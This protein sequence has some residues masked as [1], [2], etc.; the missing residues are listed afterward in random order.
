MRNFLLLLLGF[1]FACSQPEPELHEIE[2][3]DLPTIG[4]NGLPYLETGLDGVLRCSWVE[5]SGDTATLKFSTFQNE[6]WTTP[7]KVA[8]GTNWFVNWADYP[9]I[10]ASENVM[11]AHYLQKSAPDTY[12]Y[13]VKVKVRN[14]S[15]WSEPFKVHDDSTETEHGFVSIIPQAGDQFRL[16]WLDGRNTTGAHE[17]AMTLR[18]AMIDHSGNVS[19][20]TRLDERV[21]DCCATA[22]VATT[23]GPI[24]AYR[25]RSPDEIRDISLVQLMESSELGWVYNESISMDNWEIAGCP[26]NGPSIDANGN[27]VALGWFTGAQNKPRV[28]LAISS[29]GG[30]SFETPILIDSKEPF[31]RV[32]VNLLSEDL[33]GVTW[34]ARNGEE[35]L[36]KLKIINKSGMVLKEMVITKTSGARLSGFPQM[37]VQNDYLYFANTQPGSEALNVQVGRLKYK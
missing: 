19:E 36:I 34:L 15:G 7:E 16:V 21:C 30:T 13:D 9:K 33:I 18:T 24:V 26:V 8:S 2:W 6:Q 17:G 20:R 23:N 25:D 11:I 3:L 4:N 35:G 29:N 12:A 22:A 31:G 27:L 14:S 10:S 1:L 28:Q 37:A 5:T 32:A